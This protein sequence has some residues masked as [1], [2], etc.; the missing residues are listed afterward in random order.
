M[1]ERP[2]PR[3]LLRGFLVVA[4]AL[5]AVAPA[6]AVAPVPA[7]GCR[8]L[9]HGGASY[10]IC[11]FDLR[12]YALKLFLGNAD[13]QPYGSLANLA[14]SPAGANL[15]M[16]MNAGM[17]H[18]DLSPVGLYVEDGRQ[19]KPANQAAGPGNF[20]MKPNGVF[21]VAEGRAGLLETG[22]FLK[23]RLRAT[24][25]TQSGPM[26]VIDGRLHPRF[27]DEGPSRKI[28]NGVGLRDANSVVFA[29]SDEPVSFGAFARLFR[30]ELGCRNA[31]F[32]DGSISALHAPAL[33]RTDMSLKP[34][35][36]IVGVLAK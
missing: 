10:T 5:V 22:A 19:L 13:G 12:R 33:G 25:A 3:N 1:T 28:R 4:L 18:H 24:I 8:A 32:L 29:I 11:S 21:Y 9:A 14:R 31:L 36:P 15:A 34:L 27:S 2:G 35:G 7:S 30:D 6:R 16:A 17:Y 26:L 23:K 20:H